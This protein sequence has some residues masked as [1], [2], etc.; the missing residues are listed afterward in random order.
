VSHRMRC[1]SITIENMTKRKLRNEK[2]TTTKM[3]LQWTGK[4][5]GVKERRNFL[6]SLLTLYCCCPTAERVHSSTS[7]K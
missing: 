4:A 7:M 1:P 3:K 6:R 5:T 2:K